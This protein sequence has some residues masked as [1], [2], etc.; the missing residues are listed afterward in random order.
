MHEVTTAWAPDVLGGDFVARTIELGDDGDGAV[1]TLVRLGE[2]TH[3]R[4]ILYVH[5][6]SDYFFQAEHA[7]TLAAGGQDVYALDLRRYGRSL[8]EGQVPGLVRDLAEYDEE[9]LA[10]LAVVRAEG[11]RQ[12]VLLGHSTGGLIATLFAHHHPR[13]LQAVVLNSPWYDIN[14]TPLRR[15]LSGTVAAV[16]AWRDPDAVISRLSGTYG[17][18][19]HASTGGEWDFDLAWKP[20]EGFPVR[21]S[22]LSAIRR[23]QRRVAEGLDIRV[24]VLMC[25][26]SRSGGAGGTAVT[27]AQVRSSDVLLDVKHMWDAVARLGDD[28]TLRTVPGGLHDLALSAPAARTDYE[29]AVTSWIS[30]R[31]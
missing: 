12:V 29:R 11:H 9:I 16:A 22:W 24:P 20:I 4:A 13:A 6:F 10:A 25:T 30:D 3:E 18:S 8:R 27:P 2:P 15:S 28:V 17:S 26:S 14:D 19:I 1:A 7:R 21:A 23:A 31:L 5:G